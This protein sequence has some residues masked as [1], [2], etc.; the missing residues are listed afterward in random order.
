MIADWCKASR[1]LRA[2]TFGLL[3]LGVASASAVGSALAADAAIPVV[4][5]VARRGDVPVFLVGLESTGGLERNWL[6]F[7]RDERRW[8][9]G[10]QVHRLV[11]MQVKRRLSVKICSKVAL[12]LG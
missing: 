5:D 1:I 8:I 10:M 7:F 2:A 12:L 6:A 9:K 3:S 11:P 4:A